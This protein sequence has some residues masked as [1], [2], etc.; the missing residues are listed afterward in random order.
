MVS[1]TLHR[2]V[3]AN[4]DYLVVGAW[5]GV[6]SL[7]Y[8]TLAFQ[9]GVVP[10]Q[11]ALGIA[12]RVAFPALSLV[13][14]APE[15]LRDGFLEVVEHLFLALLPVCLLTAAV[16]PD[17]M[18]ALYGERWQPAAAVLPVL[19]GVG[20]LYGFDIMQAVCFAVGRPRIRLFLV[21][22]RAAVF[23]A[24]ALSGGLALGLSGVA[25]SMVLAVAVTGPW[26]FAV[27]ARLVHAPFRRLIG[28]LWPAV[29]IGAAMGVP[30]LAL[31]IWSPSLSPPVAI[32]ARGL[33]MLALY[34]TFLSWSHG[35]RLRRM[36]WE[37]RRA[38]G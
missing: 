17:F 16:G 5:L 22:G 9:L 13:R 11:R 21:A 36:L 14:E 6:E 35:S 18:A 2:G 24:L 4:I 37:F 34:A 3:V 8:Y 23:L 29:R 27:A 31:S 32:L 25:W 38:G 30:L 7:G 20:F 28:A 33:P 26:G 1:D 19:A 10:A 15:R 12:Y